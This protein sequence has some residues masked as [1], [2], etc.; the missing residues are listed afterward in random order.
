MQ[1]Q[2]LKLLE[3]QANI[4]VMQKLR[5][6]GRK[7]VDTA[8]LMAHSIK[9]EQAGW[10]LGIAQPDTPKGLA[11]SD[12]KASLHSDRKGEFVIVQGLI[13]NSE[14][15]SSKIPDLSATLVD[16]RGWPLVT[17]SVSPVQKR[18]IPGGGSHPFGFEVRP[19]PQAMEKAVVYFASRYTPPAR[20][21]MGPFC[22]GWLRG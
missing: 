15:K 18:S 13:R 4:G 12:V 21:G 17:V 5:L 11:V 22:G 1:K 7:Q 9:R 2:R 8:D 20:M 16:E 14:K 6:M 10:G 3:I 19:A